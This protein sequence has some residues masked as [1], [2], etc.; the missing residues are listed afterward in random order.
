[1]FLDSEHVTS[2]THELSKS[3]RND[4]GIHSAV[5][6]REEMGTKKCSVKTLLV[7]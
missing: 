7:C 1:M 3:F 2:K 5:Q 6:I 4:C